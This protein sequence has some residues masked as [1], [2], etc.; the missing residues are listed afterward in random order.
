MTFST[1]HKNDGGCYE[2]AVVVK[3]HLRQPKQNSVLIPMQWL[4]FQIG[5]EQDS[6]PCAPLVYR[7]IALMFTKKIP[8]L[9]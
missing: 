9:S 7:V 4:S 6:F 8:S 5:I 2:V 1:V 3:G